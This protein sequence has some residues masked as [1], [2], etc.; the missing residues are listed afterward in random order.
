MIVEFEK[1]WEQYEN[2]QVDY[3]SFAEGEI[4]DFGKKIA[5]AAWLASKEE[6]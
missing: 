5:E 2:E 4:G 6:H 3:L 1:W